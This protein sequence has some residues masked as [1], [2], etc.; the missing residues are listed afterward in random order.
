[1]PQ[2]GAVTSS[3]FKDSRI[4]GKLEAF[5]K[6]AGAYS[7]ECHRDVAL[8]RELGFTGEALPVIPNAGG[9]SKADLSLPLLEP[10]KRKTIAL[11]GCHGWAGRATV[12]LEAV[13]E[14][15]EELGQY[16]FVVYSANRL[17]IKLANQVAKKTGLDSL[18]HAK[19]SLSHQ[20]VLEMFAKSK[21]YVGLSESDGIGTSILEAMAM[22]AIPVQTSI[23]HC[24][25]WFKDSGVAVREIT[26]QS[27]KTT[28]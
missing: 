27:I 15:A 17:V 8:A 21:I 10:D 26:I 16:Q 24:D 19:R 4:T 6:L 11:K 23:A 28:I 5:L 1:L 14:V 7:V 18:D 2:T 20:Q 3:G 9:L 25:E 12:S 22:A 13:R